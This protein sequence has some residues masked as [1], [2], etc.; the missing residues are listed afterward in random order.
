MFLKLHENTS[1]STSTPQASTFL[2]KQIDLYT[3]PIRLALDKEIDKRLVR[4]FFDLF[5]VILMFRNRAMGLLLSELGGY[6]CGFSHAPAGTKR[7]S[8]LLRSPKWSAG[9]IDQFLFAQTRKRIAEL[10]QQGQRPLF[11]WDD[12]RIEKPESWSVEGLCSVWSSKAKRL[13]QI[14]DKLPVPPRSLI[15]SPDG[16]L[17]FLAFDAFLVQAAP[18]NW[19][20]THLAYLNNSYALSYT[21]SATHWLEQQKGELS[22]PPN[23]WLGIAPNFEEEQLK[24]DIQPIAYNRILSRDGSVQLPYAQKEIAQISKI[25][26]GRGLLKNQAL[27][28]GFRQ[29][30]PNYQVLHLATHGL[31]EDLRPMY[32]RLVFAPEQDSTND[33][34]LHA[35]EIYNMQLPADLVVLSACNTGIGKMEKGEGIMSLSRAFFYAGVKSILMS[36]WSVSDESTAELMLEFYQELEKGEGKDRALRQ[37]KM[38]Y[39]QNQTVAIKAHPYFWAGFVLKGNADPIPSSSSFPFIRLLII[40]LTIGGILGGYAFYRSGYFSSKA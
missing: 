12:S 15:L 23:S 33:G 6:I 39:L 2:L 37:A 35:Y 34:F 25:T 20:F 31:I 5:C 24:N 32:S 19:L 13:T 28:S 26:G 7:I 4:T 29:Q 16:I 1:K 3:S 14:R 30:A 21:H 27:E 40:L 8:N 17:N 22:N 38:N 9:L 18:E 36:L 11:L 10:V